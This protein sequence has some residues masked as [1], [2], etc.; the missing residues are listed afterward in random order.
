MVPQQVIKAADKLVQV[1][2]QSFDLVGKKNG[3]DVYMYVFPAG[4]FLG[5]PYIYL[6]K[7]GDSAAEQITGLSALQ[8]LDSL[9]AK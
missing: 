3:R 8:V 1:Y 5:Y 7:D 2:G 4:L 9:D 6:F